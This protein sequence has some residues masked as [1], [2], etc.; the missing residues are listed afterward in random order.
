MNWMCHMI[1]K[2]IQIVELLCILT[3]VQ[4]IVVTDGAGK[5]IVDFSVVVTHRDCIKGC[6]ALRAAQKVG[7]SLKV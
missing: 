5:H 7:L 1:G 3:E 4:V 6:V 2:S